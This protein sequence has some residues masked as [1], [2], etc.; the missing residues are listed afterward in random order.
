MVNFRFH[1]V[2]LTAVF[3]ALAAGITIGAGVVDRATV[4]RIERQLAQVE[5]NRRQTNA[6]NDQLAGD[7]SRWGRFSEEAGNAMVEGRLQGVG[8]FLIAVRGVDRKPIEGFTGSLRAA[9]ATVEGTLWFTAKWLLA[10][11]QD[12]RQLSGLLDV[13]PTTPPDDLRAG[14]LA[15]MTTAWGAG[16]GGTFIVALRDAA[17]VEFEPPAVPVAPLAQLPAA[18]A[19]FVV[20][21]SDGAEV[22]DAELAHPLVAGLVAAGVRVVAAQPVP[23]PLPPSQRKPPAPDFVSVLRGDRDLA[24]RLSTVDNLDDYRGRIA[25]VLAIQGASQGRS[26]HYGFGPGAERVLPEVAP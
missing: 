7:L 12:L 19:V 15:R 5:A 11:E 16:D 23:P 4:D 25:A 1:L 21:S 22:P 10:E 8:V 20:I 24:P 2:S 17:F 26:G 14:A 6:E 9:G 3:L 13:A 18:N